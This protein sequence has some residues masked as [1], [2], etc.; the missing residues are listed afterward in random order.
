MSRNKQKGKG[1]NELLPSDTEAEESFIAVLVCDGA[2]P[3]VPEKAFSAISSEEIYGQD[4]KDAFERLKAAHDAGAILDDEAIR[5]TLGVKLLRYFREEVPASGNLEFYA[6]KI[7]EAARK[8]KVAEISYHAYEAALNG[9]A[10]GDILADLFHQAEI[11]QKDSSDFEPTFITSAT[12]RPPETEYLFYVGDVG[13][14]PKNTVGA[15]AATGGTGKSFFV[16]HLGAALASGRR[17]GPIEP[18]EKMRVMLLNAEDDDATIA[19]RILDITE[20]RIPDDLLA[21][22]LSGRIEPL[23]D[24]ENGMAKRGKWFSWLD[25]LLS[26]HEVDVLILDPFSRFYGAEEN[27]STHGTAW[28]NALEYLRVKHSITIITCHHTNE[29]SQL[30]SGRMNKTMCRGTSAL[31]D[32]YRWVF[33]M[34]KMTEEDAKNFGLEGDRKAYVELDDIKRNSGKALQRPLYFRQNDQTGIFEHVGPSFNRLRDIAEAL[35]DAIYQTG[36][37]LSRRELREKKAGKEISDM[38]ADAVRFKFVRSKDMDKGIDYCLEKGLLFETEINLGKTTKTIIVRNNAAKNERRQTPPKN[39]LAPLT[40]CNDSSLTPPKD[41]AAKKNFG[42]DKC[43][44]SNTITPPKN[45]PLK[46]GGGALAPFPSKGVLGA[47]KDCLGCRSHHDRGGR[48][49]CIERADHPKSLLK[50]DTPCDQARDICGG[51][52]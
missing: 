43:N 30:N 41:N 13:M 6:S 29:V 51:P 32:G 37:E 36:A 28:I 10:S 42:V 52:Y 22:S 24:V 46:G 19:T 1:F 2:R 23:L 5:N 17:F 4:N 40:N 16:S 7:R 9:K 49:I 35:V 45:P 48:H 39:A 21:C 15:I 3:G 50:R 38:I 14:I 44:N 27:N 31:T 11:L 18:S 12:T 34:R 8:R 20:E 26:K 47:P 33:G 25:R